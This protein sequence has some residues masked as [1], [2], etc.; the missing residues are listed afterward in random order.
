MPFI[1][2][3]FRIR[4]VVHEFLGFFRF[5]TDIRYRGHQFFESQMSFRLENCVPVILCVSMRGSLRHGFLHPSVCNWLSRIKFEQ[6][7]SD[8]VNHPKLSIRKTV[9]TI[10]LGLAFL[11]SVGNGHASAQSAEIKK[12][13][14]RYSVDL[15]DVKNHYLTINVTVPVEGA[16][17]EL[18]MAVW[19]PGS[20]LVREYARNIDSMQVS[21]KG[22]KL[23][24]EKTRKNRWLVQSDGVKSFDVK[25][26]LYCNEMSV[27]TNWVGKEFAMINGAPTFMTVPNRLKN[28]HVV[29]LTM[30]RGWTRSATSLRSTG[31]TPHTFIAE[32]FDEL[33]DSPIVAGNVSVYPFSVGGVEHQL[34]NVGES[35]YWD[36][37]KAAT[38]LKKIVQSHHELWGVVPYDRYLFLNMIVESGGGLEH[39]NS[40]TLM[41]S[42]WTFRDTGRYKSWLSLASHEF[43]HTWNVRRLRPKSLV[44]YDYEN[45]VYTD[46]LWICE[47]ITSY[48][49]D[50]ELVRCGLTTRSE[51]ISKLSRN[52]ESVQR[53]GGRKLQS[54][55]D[56]S[57]DAWIKYYRPDE[58]SSY[59]D[60][61][62]YSKGAVVAFLLDAKIRKLTKGKKSLDD[63]MRRMF[64]EYEETGFT[65]EDFRETASEIA[66]LDLTKWFASA[67]DSTDELDY[68]DIE[69]IGVAVPNKKVA[70]PRP[71]D[72]KREEARKAAGEEKEGSAADKK[73]DSEPGQNKQADAKPEDQ[74]PAAA[75]QKP[76]RRNR[77]RQKETR[78]KNN[79]DS[80]DAGDPKLDATVDS[81]GPTSSKDSEDSK[82]TAGSS[83]SATQPSSRVV[84]RLAGRFGSAFSSRN[85]SPSSG[86]ST[87]WLGFRSSSSSG[88]VTVSGVT[89]GSPA[90]DV[91]LNKDDEIIAV[92][93]FRITSS[94][95][96]RLPQYKVGDQLEILIARRG[97]LMTV[98]LTLGERTSESWR[99]RLVSK[100]TE[101]QKKQL[102]LWLGSGGK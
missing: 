41:T 87:P 33:V 89:P 49:Q 38:D 80:K 59:T 81:A 91:G 54:L 74:K 51:F 4:V 5:D 97:Q 12:N 92:D 75:D 98:T 71:V 25:Y 58:N 20:Y 30:P 62:Y 48:Y 86:A 94:V 36:G 22:K 18:M 26:R 66:G 85:A 28:P 69:A 46:S 70:Q 43:F 13:A 63:V 90:W 14:I 79:A 34:V 19:T 6:F 82:K 83:D 65:P 29:H 100:P 21:A 39:D 73:S 42:R 53:T 15:A 17:T 72:E 67:I 27:R 77:N 45:E 101:A 11:Q 96:S 35:G 40:C 44:E 2:M 1:Q 56:S 9:G 16:T 76:A 37:T 47:G 8:Q 10:V 24:F 99:L 78:K 60:I 32:D 84:S 57:Y 52:V 50:L 64:S 55:K 68:S 93:G 31:D 3:I 23:K 102:D 95:D 88:Q 61:S 7:S